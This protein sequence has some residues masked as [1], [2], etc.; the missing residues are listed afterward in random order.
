MPSL[1]I[2]DIPEEVL[3]SLRERAQRNHRSLNGE[4]LTLLETYALAPSVEPREFVEEVREIQQRYAVPRVDHAE[5]D[6]L[7]RRGRE[8]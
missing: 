1:T 2:R 4:L 6:S 8:R 3:E 7:K 5:I